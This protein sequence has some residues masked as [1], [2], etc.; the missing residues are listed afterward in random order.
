MERQA[1]E[2]LPFPL[3]IEDELRVE[4]ERPCGESEPSKDLVKNR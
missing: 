1:T 2:I 4:A 3:E